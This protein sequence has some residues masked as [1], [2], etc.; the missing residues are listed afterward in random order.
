MSFDLWELL[1]AWN[2]ISGLILMALISY[3]I[4][5][6]YATLLTPKITEIA[7]IDVNVKKR[8]IENRNKKMKIE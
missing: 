8:I 4:S 5:F 3:I 2:S 7:S 6:I 1:P